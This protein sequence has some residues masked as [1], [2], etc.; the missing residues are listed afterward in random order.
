MIPRLAVTSPTAA[1]LAEEA[2]QATGQRTSPSSASITAKSQD[3]EQVALVRALALGTGED[4]E[5]DL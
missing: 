2:A 3:A 5:P 4:D 1:M